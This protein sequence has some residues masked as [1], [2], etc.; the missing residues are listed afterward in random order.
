MPSSDR[1]QVTA[2]SEETAHPDPGGVAGRSVPRRTALVV[3]AT[4]NERGNLPIV[5]ERIWAATDI[6]VL[7]VDDN[8]PDGT[9]AV[10]DRIADREPRLQVIHRAGKAGL[11][12]ALFRGYAHAFEHGYELAIEMDAD[13]SHPPEALPALI[14]ACATADVAIGSRRVPGGRVVGRPVWRVALTAS[15]CI[16]ARAVLGLP[17]HDCTS[18]YR[19]MRTE[20]LRVMDFSRIRSSGYGF[21]IELD[22]A[23]KRAGQRVVEIPITFNDRAHGLSKMRIG[24]IPEAMIMVLKLRL[25]LVPAAVRDRAEVAAGKSR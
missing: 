12:S 24:M 22:W 20:A 5:L 13:L 16:W 21:L 14:A 17:M 3:L 4:Y 8:S 18:G 1:G 7:V 25:R 11:A 2:P 23:I 9:G 19:C 15:A 10:A 6:D